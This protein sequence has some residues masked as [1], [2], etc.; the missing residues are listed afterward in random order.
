MTPT[1]SV[2]TP[3][4]LTSFTWLKLKKHYEER[5]AL[6]RRRNDKPLSEMETAYLRGEIQALKN[7]LALG[8]NL[9]PAIE[10]ADE[11]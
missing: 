9:D 7:S 1:I 6:L 4:D 5:L 2:L 10:E 11:G 8:N 3:D